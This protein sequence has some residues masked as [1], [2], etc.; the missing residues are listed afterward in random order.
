MAH[1]FFDRVYKTTEQRAVED[2]YDDWATRYDAD[3]TGNGY[4]TPGRTAA[5]L[6]AHLPDRDAPILDFACGTG[7]SGAALAAAGYTTIDGVDL[8]E[9]M[10]KTARE[11]GIY[12]HL[13]KVAPDAPPPAAPGDYAAIAAIGALSPGAAPASYF[14]TLLDCLAPGGLLALSYNDHTLAEPE[15]TGRLERALEQGR[16]AERFREHGDHLVELGSTSTV[17]I[18]EKRADPG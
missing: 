17:Y 8:S 9:E 18:L 12:R 16:V 5:A 11:L 6:A 13:V 2:L 15:Y 3:V 10:L 14:D 4:A 1:S 7:L